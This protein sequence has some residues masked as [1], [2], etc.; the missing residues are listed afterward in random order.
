MMFVVEDCQ[1]SIG[2]VRDRLIH[3][4]KGSAPELHKPQLVVVCRKTK[5]SNLL[6]V[7]SWC[8]IS[9]DSAT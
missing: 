8:R 5:Y 1:L 9:R 7:W 3:S 2:P 6:V 4:A